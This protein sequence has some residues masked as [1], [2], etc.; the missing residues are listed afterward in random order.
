[1]HRRALQFAA[2]CGLLGAAFAGTLTSER[3][4]A[5]E[6]PAPTPA[7]APAKDVAK[8]K[9][10]SADISIK[11]GYI[12]NWYTEDDDE[13]RLLVLR[14]SVVNRHSGPITVSRAAWK[15]TTEGRE[16]DAIVVPPELAAQKVSIGKERVALGD[17]KTETLEL[18]PDGE[19]ATWLVFK[20][21]PDGD[22]IPE[23]TLACAVPDVGT[24]NVDVDESFASRLKLQSRMIGP[25]N[26]IALVTID[27]ELDKIN[28]G[29]LAKT[30]DQI[31]ATRVCRVIVNFGPDAAAPDREVAGWLRTVA[32]QSGRNPVVNGDFP[33]LPTSIVDFHVV[34]FRA[35]RS[36]TPHP[37]IRQLALRKLNGSPGAWSAAARNV[38]DEPVAAIDSAIAP[39]CDSLPRE[40][41]LR[42][43]RGEDDATKAAVLRH[44]A[45]RLIG[46]SL[47]LIL[48]LTDDEN[49]NVSC[50]AIFALRTS[51]SPAAITKLVDIATSKSKSKESLEIAES[52]IRR[53]VAVRSLAASKF[54]VAHSKVVELLN[55]NDGF[56]LT[57]ASEAIVNYPRR[58]W[59]EPLAAL[60]QQSDN[61]AQAQP[62][63]RALAAVGH[64]RLLTILERC[65]TSN[66]RS[67]SA[68]ALNI[69]IARSEPVAEQLT[70]QWMLKS[71]E[72]SEPSPV[73]LS[74]LRR[75]RDHRAV[76]LLLRHLEKKKTD[77]R[78]LL[79]TIL[80]IGDHRIA[81]QIAEDFADYDFSEQL[82]ILKALADVR[83]EKFWTLTASVV[84]RTKT[85]DDKS[86]QG[87]VSLLQQR[88]GNRAV[89]LLVDVLRKLV[90]DEEHSPRHLAVVCAALASTG[91]PEAR[92]AL[93]EVV[94]KSKSGANVARQSLA[95][96]YQRSPA[97]RYVTQGGSFVGQA[98]R[99]SEIDD[100]LDKAEQA[101]RKAMARQQ[102]T[103]AMLYLDA[104]VKTDP[105]LPDARRWRA[106]AALHI[107]RPSAQQLETA[108]AD[109]AR[110]V[111][112]EPQESEGHTGLALVLVRQGRIDEGIAAGIA[113]S[114]K[115]ADDSV[116][117]YNMACIYGRAIEQLAARPDADKPDRK[118]QIEQFRTRGVE[119]LQQSIDSGLDDDNLDW[120]K[121]DP[122]LETIRQSPAFTELVE[123]ALSGD[124][125]NPKTEQPDEK[126]VA[127]EKVE[128]PKIPVELPKIPVELQPK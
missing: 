21:L 105:E 46:T 88:S 100:D 128:P 91:T 107:D 69:L 82:L 85:S 49:L 67:L 32:V 61:K 16:R 48:S 39:L 94:R 76:P 15:L 97:Q 8:S 9:T 12:G 26:A 65:L 93:R 99:L 31:S 127:E 57:E 117:S 89:R 27:G 56:L 11:S 18:Q 51:R 5:D 62:L 41:L 10:R 54:A 17:A 2:L 109:F 63:L 30:I 122:D 43:I 1:M 3:L 83:S 108:R 87:V 38:H 25:A 110:Y 77:R 118:A 35:S 42:A 98:M 20:N 7:A 126:E 120:M 74:F 36:E 45:E 73:L 86:L 64:P 53:T 40:E 28:V 121:R 78:E 119:L 115:S 52:H 72:T 60:I 80:T 79:T 23:M 68:A 70:S 44:G 22:S 113:I 123:K 116:Y 13:T 81:E 111:E 58:I 90:D 106:N 59:S 112:L 71:L 66:E 55:T 102:I 4:L 6:Q 33:A 24:I 29:E 96:L 114:E 92:D 124:D 95:Q 47:P 37:A 14:V 104:A 84:S 75:T 125:E 101:K 50:G 103:N 19:A 34:N